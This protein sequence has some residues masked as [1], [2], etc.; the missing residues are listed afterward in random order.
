MVRVGDGAE[1]VASGR[2]VASII[3]DEEFIDGTG[4]ERG[5]EVEE[6]LAG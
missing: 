5:V 1:G 6:P 3:A 2:G 4:A